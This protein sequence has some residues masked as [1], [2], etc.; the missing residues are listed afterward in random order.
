MDHAANVTLNS[1]RTVLA[2]RK[3]FV[4]DLRWRLSFVYPHKQR[5]VFT[6]AFIIV[7]HAELP[8]ATGVQHLALPVG[9][10]SDIEEIVCVTGAATYKSHPIAVSRQ[11]AA[12][13]NWA[14]REKDP[15]V[16]A[17]G[18][19]GISRGLHAAAIDLNQ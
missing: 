9:S 11:S 15:L 14:N 18:L 3:V 16:K 10:W 13:L 17:L 1:G 4:D 12:V 8:S 2:R 7:V 19:L 5:A 6:H